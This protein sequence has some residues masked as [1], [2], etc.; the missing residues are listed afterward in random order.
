MV[1]DGFQ[2]DDNYSEKR[3]CMG[4]I[5]GADN[6]SRVIKDSPKM[7]K[8]N[9]LKLNRC[10]QPVY[11]TKMLPGNTT[12]SEQVQVVVNQDDLVEAVTNNLLWTE[13]DDIYEV[14]KGDD[15]DVLIA[16]ESETAIN[17]ASIVNTPRGILCRSCSG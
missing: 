12:M 7:G 8:I 11:Y 9:P 15:G 4:N 1:L 2:R 14:V 17:C 3:V 10:V 5:H 16:S 6:N 13:N